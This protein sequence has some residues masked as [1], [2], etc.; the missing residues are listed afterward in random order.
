MSTLNSRVGHSMTM[1]G[2]FLGSTVM[3]NSQLAMT[4]PAATTLHVTECTP[5]ASDVSSGGWHCTSNEGA[6][7]SEHWLVTPIPWLLKYFVSLHV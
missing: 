6:T 3:R 2:G 5:S 4:A 7:P 1:G